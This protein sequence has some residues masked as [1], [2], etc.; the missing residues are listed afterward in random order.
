MF[1]E[2]KMLEKI[3][4]QYIIT[5]TSEAAFTIVNYCRIR[6]LFKIGMILG[7]YLSKKHSGNIHLRDETGI[8]LYYNGQYQEA[9]HLYTKLLDNVLTKKK[10]QAILFNDHFT[11][12]HIYTNQASYPADIVSQTIERL[13]PSNNRSIEMITLTITSC[14]RMDLFE[15]TV[16][17]FLRTCTDLDRI[18]RFLCIDDN[19]SNEDRQKMRNLYPFFDFYMKDISEKGH[20]QS[21]NLIKKLVTTPYIF[22]TEDDWAYFIK[23]DYITRCMDVLDSDSSLNQCLLNKNYSETSEGVDIKGGDFATT[24]LGGRYYKHQ[25]CKTD[26]EKKDFFDQHGSGNSSNYWPG[27]S[28]RPSMIRV[29][30]LTEIGDFNEKI[31]H[32]E[33]EYSHRSYATGARSAFLEGIYC[34]HIGRLTSERNDASKLNAYILNGEAQFSGKEKKNISTYV[35]N[36]DRRPDRMDTFTQ[37]NGCLDFL[38]WRRWS[39]VDGNRLISTPRLQRI[40][41]NNNY[42]MRRGMVGCALS[43]LQL[44]ISLATKSEGIYI[45]LEDDITLVPEF[46]KKLQIILDQIRDTDWDMCYLGHHVWNKS[47]EHHDPVKIP[48]ATKWDMKRSFSESMGG[49]GGYMINRNGA[50]KLLKFIENNGVTNGIDTVQQKS[51]NHLNIYYCSPHLIY[52]ELFVS[53]CCCDSDIQS[54]FN[55]LSIPKEIRVIEEQKLYDPC[56]MRRYTTFEDMKAYVSSSEIKQPAYYHDNDMSKINNLKNVSKH[57]WYTIEN[58]VFIVCGTYYEQNFRLKW[59]DIWNVD[60]AILM[61]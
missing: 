1:N 43:H 5:Q 33:M 41:N 48:V 42:N 44:I 11:Y 60:N 54:D 24:P 61:S 47:V 29:S 58:S 17:S 53:G 13:K 51:A 56:G 18:D 9:N 16:N 19:S 49:T 27:F 26:E 35:V 7:Q 14:K 32:F 30:S 52:S 50:V 46:K 21:M 55:C 40:F 2:T 3:C 59:N 31:S 12:P 39:A 25:Y 20:P 6:S 36:L 23:T 38:E 22:H 4:N 45:I 28:F 10:S 37:N 15:R 34:W 8:C 57:P